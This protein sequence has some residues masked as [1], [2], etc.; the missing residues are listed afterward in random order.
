M[1]YSIDLLDIKKTKNLYCLS[2]N[3]F[4]FKNIGKTAEEDKKRQS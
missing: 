3:P 1:T 2:K 4:I